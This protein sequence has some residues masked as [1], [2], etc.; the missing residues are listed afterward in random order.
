MEQQVNLGCMTDVVL[1]K[2]DKLAKIMGKN[3]ILLGHNLSNLPVVDLGRYPIESEEELKVI[4]ED[5][6]GEHRESLE[7]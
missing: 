5:L 1:K 2:Q 7:S 3:N 4:D 6:V